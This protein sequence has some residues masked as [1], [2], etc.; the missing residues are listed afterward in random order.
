MNRY[1]TVA[2]VDAGGHL[3]V[4]YSDGTGDHPVLR[5][6]M[7]SST[8]GFHAMP[9]LHAG[10][11][12]LYENGRRPLAHVTA[13]DTLGTPPRLGYGECAIY[14]PNGDILSYAP[15]AGPAILYQ[16]AAGTVKLSI[17]PVTGV[18]L[19]QWPGGSRQLAP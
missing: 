10:V 14:G 8:T 18:L 9:P 12:T 7:G 13:D 1:G 16:N 11:L 5:P 3:D 17:D 6:H 19:T 4:R 15:T 2:G